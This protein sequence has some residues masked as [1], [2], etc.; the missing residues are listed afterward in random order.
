MVNVCR[1]PIA[2]GGGEGNESEGEREK[3]EIKHPR[4]HKL[5]PSV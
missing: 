3:R 4:F 5:L 1:C 2:G